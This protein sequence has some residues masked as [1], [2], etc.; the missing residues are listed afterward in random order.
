[1][2]HI[3]LYRS[4]VSDDVFTVKIEKHFEKNAHY[5]GAML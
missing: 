4:E 5:A 2:G 3:L 1:M